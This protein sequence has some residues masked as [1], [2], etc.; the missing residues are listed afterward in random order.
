MKVNIYLETDKQNQECTW[1]KYG[2]VLE[3]MAG[4]CIPVTRVGFGS[5]EGT[6]HKCNLQA[7]EEALV[8]FHKECEVCVYTKDA[9]VAA[10][11]LKIDEMAATDF[12]D[13]KGKPIKNAKEWESICR[14][15]KECSIVISSHSGKHTYS[16]WMQEEMKKMEEIWGKGWSLRPEQN[17]ADMEYIG[18][19][20]RSGYKFTY[21]K[22]QKGG[23]YFDNEPENG[24]PEWMRRADEERGRRNR[25]KH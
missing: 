5:A 6:Y 24:K 8:R 20:T 17:P 18:T 2:Y 11:I 4:R 3:A 21:Y 15:I 25:H 10:R 1:R 16:V 22:D 7:L 13:T 23:I 14:K 19:I 12:K 9:F